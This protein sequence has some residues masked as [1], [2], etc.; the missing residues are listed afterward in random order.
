MD[1]SMELKVEDMT[2]EAC[3][4]SITRKLTALEGVSSA[5]VDLAAGKVTV[6]RD[7]SRASLDDLIAALGQ[8]GFRAARG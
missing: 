2:C 4:R 6:Q 3:A 8:I 5:S 1:T 7:E